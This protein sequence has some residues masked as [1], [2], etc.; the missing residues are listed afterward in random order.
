MN[1]LGFNKEPSKTTVVVAMSGGVDSSVTAGI[2]KE[3]GYNVIG[4]T[5]QLYTSNNTAK[6]G[7]CCSGLDI[8]DARRV[9][10]KLNIP[11]YVFNYEKTFKRDVIDYFIESYAKGDTP[12]PCIKCNETVKFRDLMSFAK[13]LEA[14]CMAT[15]HYVKREG[16]EKKALMY[17]ASDKSKD[18]SYF[19]FATTQ[20]QLDFLRF[21]LGSLSKKETRNFAK[22]ME[23]NVYDKK[24]SQ[25]ICFIP[26]GDYKSFIK[27][28]SKEGLIKDTL[29][30]T[31]GR[32]E[33]I[34]NFTIGQRR[35]MGISSENPLYVVDILKDSNEIIV[36]DKNK[37]FGQSLTL[38]ELNFIM[39]D[40]DLKKDN[41]EIKCSAKIRSLSTPSIGRLIKEEGIY[42]F[43]FD[44]P[45]ESITR[46]QAC[47]LYDKERVLGGGIIREKL[48]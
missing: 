2:L 3:Q 17:R 42:F 36:G 33:G 29:G 34:H 40:I 19:L 22:K 13:K 35:G 6:K 46:G 15:G 18:Q 14:D 44:E 41:F 1:S 27:I 43:I 37:L 9:A 25:D 31:L 4:I 8:Y 38:D 10:R 5:L 32:H 28:N 7:S 48:N 12:I 39:P 16:A 45:T 47:V 20:E 21:P 24:D 30:N 11:H 26:D 23:L